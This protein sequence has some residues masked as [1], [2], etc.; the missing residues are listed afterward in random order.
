[1][2]DKY[3]T[4][5]CL[6]YSEE[7]INPYDVEPVVEFVMENQR[8]RPSIMDVFSLEKGQDLLSSTHWSPESNFSKDIS[9]WEK[10]SSTSSKSL[11]LPPYLQ[12]DAPQWSD[13]TCVLQS[14]KGNNVIYFT[15][16]I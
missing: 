9:S 6:D 2:K 13:M 8:L 10:S 3:C 15:V 14:V 12:G 4:G 1:M 7:S 11:W 5:K 16:S